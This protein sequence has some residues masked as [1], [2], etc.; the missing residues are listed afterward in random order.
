MYDEIK[1]EVNV[2]G[3]VKVELFDAK[4]MEKVFEEEGENYIHPMAIDLLLRAQQMQFGG[5][6]AAYMPFSSYDF[7]YDKFPTMLEQAFL[8]YMH[9]MTDVQ[10]E[11]PS[12]EKRATGDRVAY[13]DLM[14]PYAGADPIIGTIN[15][16]E[17]LPLYNQVKFVCDFGTDKANGT[18]QS[19]Y[20]SY[21]TT[22]L[23]TER[24]RM[25]VL[26]KGFWF[27]NADGNPD[28]VTMDATYYYVFRGSTLYRV[29]KTTL[30]VETLGST[31]ISTIS[32]CH[33]IGD[34]I[35]YGNKGTTDRVWRYRIS[36]N[37]FAQAATLWANS[38]YVVGM[39]DDG[40][41]LLL[42]AANASNST[43]LAHRISVST[44]DRLDVKTPP[45]LVSTAGANSIIKAFMLDGEFWLMYPTTSAGYMGR[46][47]YSSNTFVEDTQYRDMWIQRYAEFKGFGDGTLWFALREYRKTSTAVYRMVTPFNLDALRE[48]YSFFTRKRLSVPITKNNTQAMKITY[49]FTFV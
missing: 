17:S 27:F 4:T 18:F 16:G 44:F 29:H 13:V 39:G 11:S 41:D 7:P 34:Y 1:K 45:S 47:T 46:Y 48:G 49:T 38:G 36:T 14:T 23:A 8:R 10:A 15:E 31:T 37:T 21:T 20:I 25:K 3:H 24:G 43:V 5:G 35:Y 2:K 40:T 28:A 30:A 12:T 26:N 22:S 19:V 42:Y 32:A 9:L 33:I 6:T